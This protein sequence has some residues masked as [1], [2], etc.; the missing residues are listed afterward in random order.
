[1]HAR[2]EIYSD[3]AINDIKM[4]MTLRKVFKVYRGYRTIDAI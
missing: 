2:E 4:E 3:Q 1:M